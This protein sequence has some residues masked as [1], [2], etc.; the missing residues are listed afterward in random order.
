MVDDVAAIDEGPD[1]EVENGEEMRE[2]SEI[3]ES[4]I[5]LDVSKAIMGA[6]SKGSSTLQGDTREYGE[7]DGCRSRNGSDG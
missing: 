7:D 1:K 6:M 5:N 3:N 2:G 4:E